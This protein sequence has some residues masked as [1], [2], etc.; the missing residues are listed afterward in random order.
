V[1]RTRSPCRALLTQLERSLSA[2]WEVEPSSGGCQFIIENHRTGATN[3]VS[4]GG[5]K[6]YFGCVY[7]DPNLNRWTCDSQSRPANAYAHAP[8]GSTDCDFM[9]AY[10]RQ[11]CPNGIS[12]H[13]SAHDFQWDAGLRWWSGTF[14]LGSGC[15]T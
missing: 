6:Y 8:A 3:T 9:S 15:Q 13:Y 12:W 7:V 5:L 2:I 10:A 11:L 1:T 14:Q 4:T